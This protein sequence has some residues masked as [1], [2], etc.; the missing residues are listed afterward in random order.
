MFALTVNEKDNKL[1]Y[2]SKSPCM[3]IDLLLPFFILYPISCWIFNPLVLQGLVNRAVKLLQILVPL[4]QVQPGRF[5]S[6]LP[7]PSI[8]P[9][10]TQNRQV[11]WN[12]VNAFHKAS[13]IS[14]QP[15]DFRFSSWFSRTGKHGK[16]SDT[17]FSI[18]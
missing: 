9:V 17:T 12:K 14:K 2:I 6:G 13:K 11:A 8:L 5:V 18:A 1:E 7:G 3:Y 16:Y 15:S 4:W 10:T